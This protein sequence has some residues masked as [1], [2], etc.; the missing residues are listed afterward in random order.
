MLGSSA[1]KGIVSAHPSFFATF[2]KISDFLVITIALSFSMSVY[3][4]VWYPQE[5]IA[6]LLSGFAFLVFSQLEGLYNSW[7]TDIFLGEIVSILRA[8]VWTVSLL[9]LLAFLSQKTDEYSRLVSMVWFILSPLAIIGWRLLFRLGLR[10][11]RKEGYNTKFVAIVGAGDLGLRLA[12]NIEKSPWMGYEIKGFFDD[13]KKS[14][15]ESSKGRNYDILGDLESLIDHARGGIYDEIFIALPLRSETRIRE[16]LENLSDVPVTVYVVPDLFSFRL[17]NS[18]WTDIGGMPAVSIHSSS[19]EGVGV[20]TKRIEDVVLGLLFLLICI[21]P[22]LLIAILIKLTSPGPVLFKQKRYGLNGDEI[23]VYKFRT[24]SV[25]DN[26]E[27]IV[28]AT[29][30]DQRIT[31]LGKFLRCTSLD[32]LPQFYNVLQGRMSIVGPRPHAVAHNEEYRKLIRGYMLRH[33]V[34]PGI[35]G[36]A[37]I[38]GWRGETDTLEKMEKRVEYDLTYIQNWSIWLDLKIIFLTIFKGFVNKNAY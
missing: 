18:Y 5:T 3:D 14:T 31:P 6:V 26:S 34:K 38:N 1:P 33:M 12:E 11:L 23:K 28:Q 10:S 24:M 9:L 2:L 25:C 15:V 4:R 27:V 16:L 21:T 32:E 7:R 36:W 37:Q 30:N 17:F 29:K 22:A 20:I 19:L 35:T 13:N 8:W